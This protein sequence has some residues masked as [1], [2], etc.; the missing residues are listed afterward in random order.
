MWPEG[1]PSTKEILKIARRTTSIIKS[2]IPSNVYLFGSAAV[3]LWANPGRVPGVRIDLL[4]RILPLTAHPQDVDIVV[5]NTFYDAEQIKAIIV[6]ADDRYFLKPAR[7]RDAD[8]EVLYC[9]LPGW[10]SRRRR[11]KVDIVVPPSNLGLPKI[12]ASD[13]I[14]DIPV[15][16]LFALLVMKTQGWWD[17]KDF[18][19]KV[20]ADIDDVNALLYRAAEKYV[21]YNQV[22]GQYTSEFMRKALVMARRFVRRHGR[23]EKWRAI[24][25]PL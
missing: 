5:V 14:E 19:A 15:M 9:R 7:W 11:V 17:R 23:R 10:R 18:R 8:Y 2:K 12:S 1:P 22:C 4:A 21:D 6:G 13:T 24:G 25:F 3:Y 16:P 20:N